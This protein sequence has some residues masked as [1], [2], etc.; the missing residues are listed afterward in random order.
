MQEA[1][2]PTVVRTLIWI[3]AIY[4]IV[5]FLARLFLPVLAKKMVDKAQQQFQQQYQNQQ[6]NQQNNQQQTYTNPNPNL[7]SDKPREKNKVGEYIDYE[8]ID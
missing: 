5:K 7:K 3:V 2:F 4:Y 6:N 1:G 8:E